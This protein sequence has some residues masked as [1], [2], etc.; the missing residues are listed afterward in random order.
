VTRR[1]AA[2]LAAAAAA[3]V[4][5]PALGNGF[6]LDDG[7]IVEVNPA[8]HSVRAAVRAFD[9]PYWPPANGAGQWRPL[10][11]LSFAVD[12]QLSRGSPVWLHLV[13]VGWHAAATALVVLLLA[14]Y[15]PETAALAGGV[16]FAVH[17]VHVE[18]VA[19][20]VGRA[21]PMAATL[22][23]AAL[24][25]GRSVRR[26]LQDGR[27]AWPV[28]IAL[29]AA[30]G[31]ALLCKEHAAVAVAL[32]ALDDLGS[33]G[34]IARPLPWRDY[35]AVVGLT[36]VWFLLR[37][38]V[39]AGASFALVAP[40]FFGLGALGRLSTMLPAVFVLVRLLVWPFSLSPDYLPPLVPRL[41]HLTPLGVA[42]LLLLA[43]LAFLA[44]AAWTRHR[45]LAVGLLLVGTAWLPTSN[46]LF[47]TGVVVAERTLYLA[48]AGVAL[49]AAAAFEAVERRRG[50]RVA[51]WLAAAVVI[52]FAART[53]SQEPVWR[54]NRDL[55][56][57]ALG[58]HPESYRQHQV[59]ARALVRMGDLPDAL[60]QYDLAV[61]LYPLDYYD[62]EEAASAALDAGRP[63]QA[64]GYLRRAGSAGPPRAPTETL[65]A[66]A[67][68]AVDSGASALPHAR[69]AVAL[70]P[71]DVGAARVL[72]G[73]FAALGERD[74]AIAAC[75]DFR[76]RG[77]SSFEG[78]LLQSSLLAGFGDSAAA[79]AAVD[80]AR[81]ASPADS[82]AQS[83]LRNL[84][85]RGASA[86]RA[87]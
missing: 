24:L 30:V 25:L 29:V 1:R 57:W 79:A 73:S 51:A 85:A 22:L 53:A 58:E 71:L 4:Y 44:A 62:V 37:R 65:T 43:A 14:L 55:V 74:S 28:E 15:V 47:P 82:A 21:E 26:R 32:L 19:N 81:R 77:G 33:R 38:P 87:R 16:V 84:Q 45:P 69:R 75:A 50:L 8:A 72:A 52:A 83:G 39:D 48:S 41:E 56:L 11:V 54:S 63:R 6:A 67:L 27:P 46:L 3:V 70:A 86:A 20:L 76:R 10:L 64:L 17:P 49:I 2:W 34:R 13:N 40:T 42:G 35:A 12:W 7:P 18:A 31:C 61:E 5:L 9:R 36:V 60:H 59:A 23:L 80:S 68:L 66:R 78:W